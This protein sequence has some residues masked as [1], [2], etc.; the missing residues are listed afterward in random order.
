MKTKLEQ[1]IK[2]LEAM[3]YKPD[4]IEEADSIELQW[5]TKKDRYSVFFDKQGSAYA[6]HIY[7]GHC[8]AIPLSIKMD[9]YARWWCRPSDSA[10]RFSTM[11]KWLG[12]DLFSKTS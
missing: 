11:E 3:C 6:A 7:Q 2:T 5:K 8:Q 1:T 12:L 4:R 9:Q 10:I